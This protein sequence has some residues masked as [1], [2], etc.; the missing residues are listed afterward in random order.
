MT[1][2]HIHIYTC[3]YYHRTGQSLALCLSLTWRVGRRSCVVHSWWSP[4]EN[5]VHMTATCH[6]TATRQIWPHG[7]TQHAATTHLC[8]ALSRVPSTPDTL[9]RQTHLRHTWDTSRDRCSIWRWVMIYSRVWL[10]RLNSS[11]QSRPRPLHTINKY[12]LFPAHLYLSSGENGNTA[13][14][15]KRQSHLTCERQLTCHWQ[16]TCDWQLTCQWQLSC[17]RQLTCH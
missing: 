16:L 5:H 9:H 3:K 2:T 14:M 1:R 7:P 10:T 12:T 6:R 11:L 17:E 15:T 4:S 8:P 13:L